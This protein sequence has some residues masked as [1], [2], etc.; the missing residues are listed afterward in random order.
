MEV[1]TAAERSATQ[2]AA[3]SVQQPA[4][5]V[6]PG[7]RIMVL[8]CAVLF[9]LA[10]MRVAWYGDDWL[11]TLRT[12]LNAVNGNGLTYNVD[13]RV[14]AVTHPLW[15]LVIIAVG[16]I[17]GSWVYSV[18]VLSVILSSAAVIL[19]L[20]RVRT[21]SAFLFLAVV[22]LFSN[23]VIVW[24]TSGLEGALAALLIVVLLAGWPHPTAA[25]WRWGIWGSLAGLIALT[26]LD[27]MLLVLPMLVAAVLSVRNRPR[28]IMVLASGA[29]VPLIAWFGF[30]W[31]YYGS[32]LPNTFLAKTNV[33]IP[34]SELIG[35]GLFYL[36]FSLRFD[37][38]V[39]LPFSAALLAVIIT[40]SRR[41]GLLL[42]GVA[43]YG[44]YVVWVGGDFM[45]GRFLAVPVFVALAAIVEASRD[46]ARES[47]AWRATFLIGSLVAIVT[48]FAG[49]LVFR[50][51]TAQTMPLE[52]GVADERSFWLFAAHT[53]VFAGY[54]KILTPPA[55]IGMDP[56]AL[57]AAADRWAQ[58][59]RT[60]PRP[61]AV[62][63]AGLGYQGM[64][65]GPAV[66]IIDLCALTD[67]FLA[68]QPFVPQPGPVP[69]GDEVLYSG[70]GWRIG[71]FGRPLPEGYVEAVMWHDPQR[72]TDPT[73]ADRL[74]DLWERI[75]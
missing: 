63:Y 43:V 48:A 10:V 75:R 16:S 55:V 67:R 22:L 14:S 60:P 33:E 30:A 17:T 37:S 21:A 15:L 2:D 57:E 71:H 28:A 51:D 1:H 40:R 20:W 52:R 18:M 26:R 13:E 59:G 38:L 41:A 12:A 8:V 69:V 72:L 49:S 54:P 64:L 68:M 61:T 66:H 4:G 42:L 11:I 65:A 6:G 23:T 5:G 36:R 47:V 3:A 27:L 53:N 34:A 44:G 50:A 19:L 73:Q 58:V 7:Q 62:H 56:T 24:S 39:W 9:A 70:P 31:S 46:S 74:R 45:A 32:A 35:Q 25:Y 29:A